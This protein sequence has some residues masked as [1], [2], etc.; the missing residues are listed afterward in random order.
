[1]G[2]KPQRRTSTLGA[3]SAV[4]PMSGH[5]GNS[6]EAPQRQT[7]SHTVPV[8]RDR[9]PSSTPTKKRVGYYATVSQEERI[10]E[11]FV[12]ARAAGYQWRS[13]SDFQLSAVLDLVEKVETALND[14]QPFA[15]LPARSL[16]PGKPIS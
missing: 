10:R 8:Q 9:T 12:A 5:I 3:V 11:A 7:E 16:S 14:G 1:M 2:K 13:L 15:G 4:K 6:P